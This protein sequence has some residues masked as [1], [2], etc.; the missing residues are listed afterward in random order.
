MEP[1]KFTLIS[2]G[3]ISYSC[4]HISGHHEPIPT[5]FGV[6]RFFSCSTEIWRKK[7]WKC[8]KVFLMTSSLWYSIESKFANIL[9]TGSYLYITNRMWSLELQIFIMYMYFIVQKSHTVGEFCWVPINFCVVWK[10]LDTSK[11]VPL[12]IFRVQ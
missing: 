8:W 4:G 11:F 9:V 10:Y 2:M 1:G 12:C 3:L 5:K 6:W 7:S